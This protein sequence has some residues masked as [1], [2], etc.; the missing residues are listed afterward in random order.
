MFSAFNY[1]FLRN[2]LFVSARLN[3]CIIFYLNVLQCKILLERKKDNFEFV[4]VKAFK[5][6]GAK[7]TGS[8]VTYCIIYKLNGFSKSQIQ[9][10]LLL[11]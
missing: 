4:I 1:L 3:E 2:S 5:F 7:Q 9:S 11:R 8:N 10:C 6:K